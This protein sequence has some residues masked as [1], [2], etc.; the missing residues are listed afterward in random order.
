MSATAVY[1]EGLYIAAGAALATWIFSILRR[2]VSIVDSLWPLLFL[3]MAGA[4]ALGAG[5]VG[6]R[7]ALVLSL[8]SAW[9]VRLSSYITWRNWGHGEDRRYQA[10]RARNQPNFPLKSLY[11]VF[12]LQAL[13]AWIISLPL[14]AAILNVSPLG[15][16]DVLGLSLIHI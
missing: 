4:Y 14:L 6:P 1:L 15:A 16:W 10:I 12:A 11:L 2:D 7:T 3:L 8:V 5:A 9:A 13:L